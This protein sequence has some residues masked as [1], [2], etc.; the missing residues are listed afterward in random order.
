ME[1]PFFFIVSPFSHK[2][3]RCSNEVSECFHLGDSSR[4]VAGVR[5]ASFL[6]VFRGG[7]FGAV[8]GFGGG[9]AVWAGGGLLSYLP[10]EFRV[11]RQS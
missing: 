10:L 6:V 2:L 4:L 9:F 1:E 5:S 3:L 8:G 11:H 7:W